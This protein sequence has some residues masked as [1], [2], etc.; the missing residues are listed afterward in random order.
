[1]LIWDLE[2]ILDTRAPVDDELTK[3]Y[4]LTSVAGSGLNCQELSY[5]FLRCMGPSLTPRITWCKEKPPPSPNV[6]TD[7]SFL[8]PGANLAHGTFGSWEPGRELA[9]LTPEEADF[10]LPVS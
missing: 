5:K 1:M 2:S 7:G 9:Q 6:F 4:Q 3:A 8:H 10:C